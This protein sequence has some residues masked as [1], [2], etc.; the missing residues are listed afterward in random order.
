MTPLAIASPSACSV[1]VKVGKRSGLSSL[2]AYSS[3][4]SASKKSSALLRKPALPE[5]RSQVVSG[6]TT[7][8]GAACACSAIDDLL[9]LFGEEHLVDPL[10]E[11]LLVLSGALHLRLHLPRVRGE[12]QDAVPH[13]HR[14]RNG[15]GDEKHG[16]AGVLPEP[17]KLLLHL[18][19]GERVERGERLVHEQDVRLDRHGAGDRDPLL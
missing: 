15:M 17:E 14:F 6:F 1:A 10:R 3:Q 18:A 12:E 8:T 11:P 4:R 5:S 19:A 16:K 13:Q 9:D 2:R 7:T